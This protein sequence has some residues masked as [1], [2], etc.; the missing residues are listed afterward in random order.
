MIE[1][2]MFLPNIYI[3]KLSMRGVNSILEK[4]ILSI[5]LLPRHKDV[6]LFLSFYLSWAGSWYFSHIFSF[7]DIGDSFDAL[8]Y[9]SGKLLQM[10]MTSPARICCN[11]NASL[12]YCKHILQ[13]VMSSHELFLLCTLGCE[14][15]IFPA[16]KKQLSISC[17]LFLCQTV[18][19]IG[20][21]GRSKTQ[22]Q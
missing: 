4:N 14:Y 16:T 10:P 8:N 20:A 2:Q 5:Y 18:S 21:L 17:S 12:Q 7:S 22:T 3:Y 11:E 6:L 15:W 9:T 13:S 19:V 1:Q